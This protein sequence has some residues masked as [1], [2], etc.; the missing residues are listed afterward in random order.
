MYAYSL[1]EKIMKYS[2]LLFTLI[3]FVAGCASTGN[4]TLKEETESSVATKIINNVT[5]QA[6]IKAM[7][8]SPYE[9]TFT[10]GGMEIW[11]YRLD[12]LK[13]DAINYVPLVNLF[14][15]SFSGTRKELVILFNDDGTVKR[16]SMSESDV[17]N[18]SGLFN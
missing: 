14:G 4:Q 18:K 8:G 3:I 7:Y 17:Q 10:D 1:R 6:E 13:A 2:I 15:S 9:T 16:N 11:K 12:D 5:T